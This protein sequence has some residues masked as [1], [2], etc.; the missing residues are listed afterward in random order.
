MCGKYALLLLLLLGDY[1]ESDICGPAAYRVFFED[2]L[3]DLPAYMGRAAPPGMREYKNNDGTKR[4][5]R[6][7]CSI[8]LWVAKWR[9]ERGK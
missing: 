7:G 2:D 9:L 8:C 6:L 5:S 3:E 4:C 1:D